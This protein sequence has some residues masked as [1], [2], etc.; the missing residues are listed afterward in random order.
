M[1]DN[2]FEIRVI[3]GK[4][5]FFKKLNDAYYVINDIVV[6]LGLKSDLD[7]SHDDDI[8]HCLEVVKDPFI[9]YSGSKAKAILFFGGEDVHYAM[10]ELWFDDLQDEQLV[11]EI[12]DTLNE[13][14]SWVGI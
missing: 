14:R 11:K 10:S 7:L 1:Y 2:K 9:D 12:E 3:D 5:V 6:G 4:D 13:Y 8:L